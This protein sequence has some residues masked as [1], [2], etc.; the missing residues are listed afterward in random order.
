VGDFEVAIG[1]GIWVAIRGSSDALE[2]FLQMLEQNERHRSKF[3]CSSKN[4]Y[5]LPSDAAD[6]GAEMK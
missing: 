4:T 1:G 6:G 2:S 3:L 5:F